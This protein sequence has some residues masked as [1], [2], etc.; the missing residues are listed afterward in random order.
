MNTKFLHSGMVATIIGFSIIYFHYMEGYFLFKFAGTAGIFL[1]F[2]V[3]TLGVAASV[4]A[5]KKHATQPF[6]SGMCGVRLLAYGWAFAEFGKRLHQM[7]TTE[8]WV[9]FLIAIVG[10]FVDASNLSRLKK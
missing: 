9:V 6:T 5:L 3:A 1:A 8:R 4:D 10:F 7:Q 2:P